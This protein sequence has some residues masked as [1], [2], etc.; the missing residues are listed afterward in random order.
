MDNISKHITYE[1]AIRSETAQKLGIKNNPTAPYL[2]NMKLVAENIF[3]KAREHFGIPIVVSSFFRCQMLNKAVG[4]VSDSQHC[5]G[6]A[7]D[8]ILGTNWEL[9][10]YIRE[11][12]DFDQLIV[13]GIDENNNM[14]W[15][16]CSYVNTEK[17]RHDVLLMK[18]INGKTVYEKYHK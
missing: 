3:E 9:F 12:L 6:S 13:E 15:V 8:M 5:F 17:N 4:G 11:N 1:E 7:L 18:K 2:A 16:H 10:D 14:A